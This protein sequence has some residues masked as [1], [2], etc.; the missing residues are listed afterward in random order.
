MRMVQGS[1]CRCSDNII[2]YLPLVCSMVR[3]GDHRL[4]ICRCS[5][6]EREAK[7]K[8]RKENPDLVIT[9]EALGRYATSSIMQEYSCNMIIDYSGTFCSQFY[10]Q[11][12]ISSVRFCRQQMKTLMYISMNILY[13]PIHLTLI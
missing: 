7:G 13:H 2:V 4:L 11:I 10:R 1:L 5:D 12:A 9:L 3:H 8:G 6:D